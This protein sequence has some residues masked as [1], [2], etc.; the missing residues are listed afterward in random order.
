[1]SKAVGSSFA[2]PRQVHLDLV[3]NGKFSLWIDT[4]R[5]KTTSQNDESM[6]MVS[7]AVTNHSGS[8]IDTYINSR[9]FACNGAIS[10]G[11]LSLSKHDG[12]V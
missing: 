4:E 1:M 5:L 8:S 11:S 9:A 3:R 2:D 10:F 6:G 12:G 7:V